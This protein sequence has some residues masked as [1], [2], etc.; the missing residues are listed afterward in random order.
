MT[1]EFISTQLTT[2]LKR[3]GLNEIYPLDLFS[4]MT[5]QELIDAGGEDADDPLYGD[6][7]EFVIIY[8][9]HPDYLFISDKDEAGMPIH[10]RFRHWFNE[11]QFGH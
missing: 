5:R 9:D 4:I 2:V 3:Q 8:S 7:Y 6:D 10:S 11:L 1:K